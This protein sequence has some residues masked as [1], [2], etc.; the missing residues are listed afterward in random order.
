MK[1]ERHNDIY[2]SSVNNADIELVENGS[3]KLKSLVN[4]GR[5]ENEKNR[6]IGVI[7]IAGG[8]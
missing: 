4:G 1:N 8:G 6:I 2:N 3:V 7:I 5:D